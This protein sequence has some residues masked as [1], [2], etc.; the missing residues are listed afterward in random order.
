[1]CIFSSIHHI[2]YHLHAVQGALS[3]RGAAVPCCLHR[4]SFS[5]IHSDL[6]KYCKLGILK[7]MGR[8]WSRTIDKRCHSMKESGLQ[9]LW[10]V[11]LCAKLV[12]QF[13]PFLVH[14]HM[15]TPIMVPA[16]IRIQSVIFLP[17][18]SMY[19]PPRV[20]AAATAGSAHRGERSTPQKY[21]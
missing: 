19:G 15:E 20:V 10:S 1:M 17:S 4:V 8:W 18:S 11:H 13:P 7:Y 5:A 3:V 2:Q 12:P 21:R 16:F 6:R 9:R 14:V